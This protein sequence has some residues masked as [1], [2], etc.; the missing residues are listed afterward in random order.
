MAKNLALILLLGIAV[1]S[2]VKYRFELKVKY[3]LQEELG[4]AQSQITTLANEKQ[5]LLQ[6]LKKEK[7]LTTALEEKNSRLKEN[8][9][10]STNKIKRLF[11]DNGQVKE[12]LEETEARL[13]VL[14]AENKALIDSRKKIQSENEQFKMKFNSISELK[15]AI[16]DLKVNR[17][18]SQDLA[19]EGNQGFLFKDGHS[20][21]KIEV[22]PAQKP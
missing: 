19:A 3:A 21:V 4:K 6:D 20:T 2:M 22:I 8:L 10:A 7:E 15:Q 17:R 1:F 18:R 11:S 13:S 9:K 16:R 5:N 12:S 14:K